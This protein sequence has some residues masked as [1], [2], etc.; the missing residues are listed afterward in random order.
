[1]LK[2]GVHSK[3]LKIEEEPDGLNFFFRTKNH[4]LAV[5]DFLSSSVPN[6]V[7]ESKELVSHDIHEGTYNYKYVTIFEMPKVCKDVVAFI[8][9][10]TAPYSKDGIL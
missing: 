4:S 9:F 6:K 5:L 3:A 1:M 7:K 10:I 8:E 2:L